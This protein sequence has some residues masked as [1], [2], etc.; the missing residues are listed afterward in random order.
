MET[1]RK[2][3]FFPEPPALKHICPAS[4]NRAA[5]DLCPGFPGRSSKSAPLSAKQSILFRLFTSTL[6][7][8]TFT[9][10]GG[11]VIVT[12]LKNTF[13][14]K[15]HWISEDEMLDL[16]AIAQSSPGA[17]A[18]N[19]AIVI[20]YRLAGISGVITAVLGAVIPPMAILSLVSLC[21][22]AFC[23]NPW[24][25][26]ALNGMKAGVGA[27]IASTVWDMGR[28]IIRAK[29]PADIFIMILSFCLVWFG[30]VNIIFIILITAA[31]G[32][33]RA[34]FSKKGKDAA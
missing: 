28:N 17:V 18:V 3:H 10:G 24:I 6:Y 8:S 34:L 14:D 27:V 26:A 20:G 32:A 30:D 7:L 9:F 5:Y 1:S 31:L 23:S 33:F 22:T 15:Y 29:D 2:P 13:V 21:Y 25:A 11:Y 16:T 12:L 4:Q 19:G